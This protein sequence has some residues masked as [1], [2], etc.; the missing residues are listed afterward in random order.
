V[1][2]DELLDFV[3]KDEREELVRLITDHDPVADQRLGIDGEL[4]INKDGSFDYRRNVR[5]IMGKALDH[6]YPE[7]LTTEGT[8]SMASHLAHLWLELANYYDILHEQ[9]S[10][11]LGL[12][13]SWLREKAEKPIRY[14]ARFGIR[15]QKSMPMPR[16]KSKS[17]ICRV[18]AW[19]ALTQEKGATGHE[20]TA[21]A[22]KDKF[23]D[24][25]KFPHIKKYY[26]THLEY[27]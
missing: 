18:E 26:E 2:L 11:K 8:H 27:R 22:L 16:Y 1:R 3:N 20:T 19:S 5:G 24:L 23:P 17:L 14:L 25:L 21:T 9:S 13:R 12:L 15:L 4:A 7:E 10:G 6:Y